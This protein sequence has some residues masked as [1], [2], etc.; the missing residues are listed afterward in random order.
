MTEVPKR[1]SKTLSG[2]E[3]KTESLRESHFLQVN[4]CSV[5]RHPNTAPVKSHKFQFVD[6]AAQLNKHMVKADDI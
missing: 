4:Q 1:P 6:I 3:K 5:R 2:E